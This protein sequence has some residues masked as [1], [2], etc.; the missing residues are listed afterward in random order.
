MDYYIKKKTEILSNSRARIDP[1]Y[2][3]NISKKNNT[4]TNESY[5]IYVDKFIFGGFA[6]IIS[7]TIT[8]PFERY[9]ILKQMY[10]LK[11]NNN[12]IYSYYQIYKIEGIKSL[13]K[14]NLIN[15]YRIFPQNAIQYSCFEYNKKILN[16]SNK[17]LNNFMSGASAGIISYSF[18]YPLETIR[19]K[20]SAQTNNNLYKGIYDCITKSVK[21]NGFKS[22][23]KGCLISAMGQI[24][25]QGIN[26]L[27]YNYLNDNYNKS[28]YKLLNFLFGSFAGILSVS[29]T[30]PFDTIKRKLQL[31]GELGNPIY[32]NALHCI[33]YNYYQ[34]GL[35][36]FYSGIIPC[37]YK[38]FP[39]NGIFFL[40]IELFK[41]YPLVF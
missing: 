12:I 41:S 6:G 8:S 9:K 37:F 15:C 39:A 20:L 40:C 34:F 22:L 25:F 38:I 21:N 2:N 23:Y 5:K 17:N 24:P 32:K 11:Y 27:S 19:S 33:K 3:H 14:G 30:F 31:S 4:N 7:R 35:K 13:F 29:A 28:S 10:P 26:F 1:S 18:V 36:G 16:L